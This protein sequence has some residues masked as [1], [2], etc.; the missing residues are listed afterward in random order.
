MPDERPVHVVL[1]DGGVSSVP[2][3]DTEW[4]EMR[5]RDTAAAEETSAAEDARQADLAAVAE[6]AAQDPAI[7]ALARLIGI[8]L[9]AAAPAAPASSGT[10][11]EGDPH[12][13]D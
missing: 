2:V 8:T 12:D 10:A 4:A 5:A 7:A 13:A 1:A 3:G 6:R 9:P 11:T